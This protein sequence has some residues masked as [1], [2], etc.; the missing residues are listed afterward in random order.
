MLNPLVTMNDIATLKKEISSEIKSANDL[1]ALDDV[2]VSALGKKG[3]ITA[4][5]KTLGQMD[6][7]ERKE[8]GQALNALKDEVASLIKKQEIALK[9]QELDARLV[10]EKMDMTLDARPQGK[11]VYPSDFPDD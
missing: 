4:V 8:K 10:T 2:R 6:E 7:Q 1:K 11:R 9:K 5:M 3:R